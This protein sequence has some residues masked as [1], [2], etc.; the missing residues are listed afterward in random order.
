MDFTPKSESESAGLNLFMNKD[1]YLSFQKTR[2]NGKEV[3]VVTKRFNGKETEIATK[4]Y[5]SNNLI[6]GVYAE[7]QDYSFRVSSDNIHWTTIADKVDGRTLSRTNAGG[8]TGAY[9]AMYATSSGQPSSNYAD[10]DWFSYAET[11]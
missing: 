10:F 6:L 8:F 3:L 2:R 5:S 1:F 9:I 7:G 11:K 4:E